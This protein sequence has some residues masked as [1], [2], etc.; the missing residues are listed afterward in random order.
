MKYILLFLSLTISIILTGCSNQVAGEG[1]E[2][3]NQAPLFE[4]PEQTKYKNNP[5]A[6]DDQELK[7][8]GDQAEDMDGQIA[9]KAI[10]EMEKYVEVGAVQM[11]VKDVKVLNYSPSPDLVDYFH[12]FTHNE[13]NFNY[14][15]F[16]VAIKNT[17]DQKVNVAPVEVLKTNTGEKLGFNDDFYLEKLKGE[18][19]PGETRVGQM[20]FVLEQDWEE[21]ETVIIETSDVLDE[22]GNTVA[23]G[24]KIEVEWEKT[25]K[26]GKQ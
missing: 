21:L 22:E 11:V 9:L 23:E 18:Y 16:T 4:I 20:G 19:E 12:A 2:S 5:Q 17:G 26:F 14:I 13:T 6:P 25:F 1:N 10:K 3:E 8:V 15:K 7:E 24:E